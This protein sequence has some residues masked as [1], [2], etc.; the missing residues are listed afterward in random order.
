MKHPCGIYA[1]HAVLITALSSASIEGSGSKHHLAKRMI[2]HSAA[3]YV[4][5]FLRVSQ[6]EISGWTTK[7]SSELT[8]YLKYSK[9]VREKL[10]ELKTEP[11]IS[12][13]RAYSKEYIKEKSPGDP[14]AFV[15][16]QEFIN[17]DLLTALHRPW[18]EKWGMPDFTLSPEDRTKGLSPELLQVYPRAEIENEEAFDNRPLLLSTEIS[19]VE[20]LTEFSLPFASI[21][22]LTT[23]LFNTVTLPVAFGEVQ[24]DSLYIE[25]D[26]RER[27]EDSLKAI[28]VHLGTIIEGLKGFDLQNQ[29]SGNII[30]PPES[31]QPIV[32]AIQKT[33]VRWE[34]TQDVVGV[35]ST[36][37]NLLKK[38]PQ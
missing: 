15:S 2:S 5:G 1:L 14:F 11:Y 6:S 20:Y 37:T 32:D 29:F 28:H 22:L 34:R 3:D 35:M 18:E 7:H 19:T 21:S 4:G 17:Q 36:I 31:A 30:I 27:I 24:K 25:L 9:E 38:E 13:L 12:M 26:R 23:W 16:W 8:Y 33:I 10:A